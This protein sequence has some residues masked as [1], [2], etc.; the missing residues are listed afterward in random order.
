M[1]LTAG[2]QL[3]SD[4]SAPHTPQCSTVTEGDRDDDSTVRKPEGT[5]DDPNL[6]H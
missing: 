4:D 1:T 6:K 2:E 3:S 5:V